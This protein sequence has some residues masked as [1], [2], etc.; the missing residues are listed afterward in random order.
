[1]SGPAPTLIF[2][3]MSYAFY[4]REFNSKATYRMPRSHKAYKEHDHWLCQVKI[5]RLID[6][7]R[8]DPR[9]T[10]LLKKINLD[11]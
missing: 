11:K 10:A 3:V 4:K 5:V 1:M 6:S 8:S 7:I 2:S 9:Y